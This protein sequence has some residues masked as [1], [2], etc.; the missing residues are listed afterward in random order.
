MKKGKRIYVASSWRN[1]EQPS[2]VQFLRDQMHAVYDF[3][4]PPNSTG[5]SWSQIDG[6]WQNWTP[7]QFK[8]ALDNHIA[9]KGFASDQDAMDWA[10]ICVLV[11]PSGR[12]AHLEAGYM[13]GQ[14]KKVVV[15]MP[16]SVEPELMYRL[17]GQPSARIALTTSQLLE[18]VE[19]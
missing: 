13:A 6:N 18:F 7:A 5:F 16:K 9:K 14:Q 1:E 19:A 12:S 4:N 11:L 8:S 10:D 3:R 15:Y 17:L 2:V